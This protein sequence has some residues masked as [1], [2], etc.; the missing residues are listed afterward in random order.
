MSRHPGGQFQDLWRFPVT[1]QGQLEIGF[2]NP[3]LHM[4]SPH[5][6][7]RLR[8]TFESNTIITTTQYNSGFRR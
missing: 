7:A 1:T 2:G 4:L 3:K 6:V 5:L 8:I